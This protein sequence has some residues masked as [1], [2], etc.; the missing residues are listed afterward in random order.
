MKRKESIDPARRLIE[1]AGPR[2]RVVLAFSGGVDSTVLAH[3]LQRARRKLG[4]L[5]LVHVD[6][7]LQPGSAGWARHC[8]RIARGWSVPFTSLR[9]RIEKR[10][11]ASPEAAAREARYALLAAAMQSGEL[12]VTAQHRDDQVETLLLQLFRGAGV[13]GLAAMPEFAAFGPGRIAR[14]LLALARA[15]LEAYARAH[16]LQWVEDPSNELTRFGRNFLRHR[17]LPAIRERWQGVD[18]AIARSARHMAEADLLLGAVARRDLAV[19]VDGRGVSVVGLRSLPAARRRNALRA[20]IAGT[21]VDAPSNAKMLEIVGPLL[22]ARADAQPEVR[23]DGHVLRRR[24]GRLE[25]H[26]T[27]QAGAATSAEN[28]QKSWDWDAQRQLLVNVRDTL[29]LRGDAA[30]PIDLDRLPKLL[31]VRARE[32]GETIRPGARARTRS[33]KKLLQGVKLSAEERARMPLLFDGEGPK[34]ALLAAGD[35]WIDASIG[36]TVK[37]RR[38]ARLIWKKSV[39]RSPASNKTEK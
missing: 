21:G 30:G 28:L 31:H 6:H 13:A 7:G 1:L 16:R 2:P 8:A 39:S 3:A 29:C 4:G 35:R 17:I 5:R 37:S 15:D 25:L 9:A 32:G 10:R 20:Y 38:R 11:G 24:A 12:L 23:W 27:S 22:S 34:A 19:V 33:L 26:V 14:P 18:A 36:A